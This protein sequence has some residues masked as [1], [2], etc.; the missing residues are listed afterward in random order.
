MSQKTRTGFVLAGPGYTVYKP[1][2][3]IRLDFWKMS[4]QSKGFLENHLPVPATEDTFQLLKTL[5]SALFKGQLLDLCPMSSMPLTFYSSH[6][7]M[8]FA[9]TLTT[10]IRGGSRNSPRGRR[11]LRWT[12]ARRRRK[13]F[14]HLPP[15]YCM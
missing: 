9:S 2:L 13:N 7:V 4:Q 12:T 8:S 6:L 11:S 1:D 5:Q 3:Y 15:D 10:R 14:F